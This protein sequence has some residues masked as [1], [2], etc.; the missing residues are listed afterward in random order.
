MQEPLLNRSKITIYLYP[1]WC[2]LVRH[3]LPLSTRPPHFLLH[4][5]STVTVLYSRECSLMHGIFLSLLIPLLKCLLFFPNLS[6]TYIHRIPLAQLTDSQADTPAPSL[7]S[8]LPCYEG[9][10]ILLEI[11]VRSFSLLVQLERKQHS[12]A[13]I[14]SC[15][16]IYRT[17]TERAFSFR[18]C[19]ASFSILS[20]LLFS[21]ML[22]GTV[23][24]QIKQ[25]LSLWALKSLNFIV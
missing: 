11:V 8:F 19:A 12:T 20:S 24:S 7:P 14:A 18:V 9:F 25:N 17:S 6:R 15:S 21:V 10:L 13:S 4:I 22:F 3:S 16:W 2:N 23:Q 1:I 5:Y